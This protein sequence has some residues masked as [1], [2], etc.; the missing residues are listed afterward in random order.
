VGG[1]PSAINGPAGWSGYLLQVTNFTDQ[2]SA[3]SGMGGSNPSV[4]GTG[5]LSYWNGA[6]YTSCT[7][8]TNCPATV[9]TSLV[10]VVANVTGV[11]NV[12]VKLPLTT[13][14]VNTRTTTKNVPPTAPDALPAC[15]TAATCIA[16]ASATST[17]P[18]VGNLEYVVTYVVSGVTA[19]ASDVTVDVN[20]GSLTASTRYKPTS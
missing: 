18:V 5:T 7:I 2:V 12:E 6:G 20:L 3:E 19:V 8:G 9:I 1:L 17:S 15:V 13:W 11:G 14:T 16:N 4:S 10:D